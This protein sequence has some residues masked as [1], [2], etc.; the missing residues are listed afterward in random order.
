MANLKKSYILVRSNEHAPDKDI[1]LGGIIID[2]FEPQRPLNPGENRIPVPED[3]LRHHSYTAWQGDETREKSNSIGIYGSFL[4]FLGAGGDLDV[5]VKSGKSYERNFDELITDFFEPSVEYLVES[6]KTGPVKDFVF[7]TTFKK[8]LYMLTG[9]KIAYGARMKSG[10][11]RSHDVSA[12]LG[13]SGTVFGAPGVGEGGPKFSTASDSKDNISFGK[14]SPFV[15]AYRLRK[16]HYSRRKKEFLQ[17]DFS[18]HA[19][20]ADET[21]VEETEGNVTGADDGPGTIYVSGVTQEDVGS[22]ELGI[23][24]ADVLDEADQVE[25]E[26]IKPPI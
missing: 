25:V 23:E 22:D 8:D 1:V 13:I 26:C 6:L 10:V 24:P 17:S 4:I 20:Y 19:M 12:K 11:S 7:R 14:S 16:I 21:S 9:V 15:F 2:P 3:A 5:T 18:K